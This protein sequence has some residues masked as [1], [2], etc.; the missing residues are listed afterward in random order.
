[1]N[2]RFAIR[3]IIAL[4]LLAVVCGGLVG[5]NIFR[6]RAIQQY[7][8]NMPVAAADRVDGHGE[9]DALDAR[10]RGDRHRERPS[11]GVD[12][13][14]ETSRHRQGDPLQRQPDRSTRARSCVQLDDAVQ[15]ADLEAQRRKP[16]RPAGARTARWS[17]RRSGVGSDVNLDTAQAASRASASQVAKLQA[18]LDQKQLKAPFSGTV[19]I[20][21]IEVGQYV[22]PAR[23]S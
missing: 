19:G 16:A 18:V 9:A 12:L 14:V 6:D 5:F 2:R 13:T 17:C 23:S 20:P 21:R 15:R 1:M 7:F 4:V 3:F 11:R 10:H 8:A 22:A